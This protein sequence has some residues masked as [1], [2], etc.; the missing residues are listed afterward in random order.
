MAA[1]A[2]SCKLQ[3]FCKLQLTQRRRHGVND[4]ISLRFPIGPAD[5]EYLYSQR[6]PDRHP[7]RNVSASTCWSIDFVSQGQDSCATQLS[8][9]AQEFMQR[10]LVPIIEA[11]LTI[12]VR[13]RPTMT[14]WVSRWHRFEWW[15][16]C[17][18]R[19]KVKF[20]KLNSQAG[21]SALLLGFFRV[22]VL[23]LRPEKGAII[24]WGLFSFRDSAYPCS[25]QV[26][27]KFR[28]KSEISA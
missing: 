18:C 22:R 17:C 3:T 28:L 2:S 27:R 4:L 19:S 11:Q 7:T 20:S 12:G 23:Y 8:R 15:L 24:W 1:I 26:P 10:G 25:A 6:K 21:F 9:G 5:M 14:S 16:I 13:A